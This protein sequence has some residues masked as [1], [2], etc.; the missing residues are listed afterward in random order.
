MHILLKG[1]L[2]AAVALAL[3]A[4]AQDDEEDTG[5]EASETA[6][7]AD[8]TADGA[9]PAPTAAPSGGTLGATLTGA[10]EVPGPGDADGSGTFTARLDPATGEL[11]YTLTVAD[12]EPA[13]AAHIH[14]GAT[15][16]AG[17]PVVTLRAP[18]TGRSEECV[19][20]DTELA[21]RLLANPAGYYVN[22][23]T[24]DYP[25]GAVRGQLSG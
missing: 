18:S 20:V 3:A 11:C 17:G 4:C 2:G 19:T 21:E 12:I 5:A 7:T 13:N 16:V 1:A 22:A 10:M 15:G 25:D 14:T 6:A 8:A 23:H 24:A 9:T